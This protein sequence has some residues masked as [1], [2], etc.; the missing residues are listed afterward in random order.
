MENFVLTEHIDG[1][2]R[3]VENITYASELVNGFVGQ[4]LREKANRKKNFSK[5]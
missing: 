5:R 2:K 1:K 4:G 3:T